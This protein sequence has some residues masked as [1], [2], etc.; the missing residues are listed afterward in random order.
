MPIRTTWGLDSVEPDDE[1]AMGLMVLSRSDVELQGT[2][3]ESYDERATA[4]GT[5]RQLAVGR[6]ALLSTI[7]S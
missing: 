5:R 7:G 1:L 3:R 2:K 4:A 6:G